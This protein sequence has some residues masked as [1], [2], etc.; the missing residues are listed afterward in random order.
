MYN[1]KQEIKY[2]FNIIQKK[3]SMYSIKQNLDEL[4]QKLRL[5]DIIKQNIKEI[6][7]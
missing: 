2:E 4:T 5:I 3:E 6:K 7:K 1:L